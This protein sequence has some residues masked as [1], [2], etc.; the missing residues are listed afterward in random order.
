MTFTPTDTTDYNTVT[1]TVS[2]V[3]NNKTTPTITVWPTASALTYGQ[4]LSSS[5]LT[6]V[7]APFPAMRQL[8]AP[9]PGPRRR[10]LPERA[11]LRRA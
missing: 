2:V 9:S 7:T 5:T 8:P 4:T 10:Q 1:V 3:V 11:R 6:P